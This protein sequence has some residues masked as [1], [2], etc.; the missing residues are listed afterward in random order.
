MELWKGNS[1]T[2]A[3]ELPEL[4]E[5]ET[6]IYAASQKLKETKQRFWERKKGGGKGEKGGK[7]K[8]EGKG[9]GKDGGNMAAE[10]QQVHFWTFLYCKRLVVD[11]HFFYSLSLSHT[12]DTQ[13]K[14]TALGRYM[15]FRGLAL[16]SLR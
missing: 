4:L 7:G 11:Q 1:I 14:K 5:E 15:Y 16:A 9:K 12:Y 2:I 8:S 6:D 3:K 10:I 13:M